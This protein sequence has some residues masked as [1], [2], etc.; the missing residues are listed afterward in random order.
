MQLRSNT[1]QFWG[2]SDSFVAS[3]LKLKKNGP[4]WKS[5]MSRRNRRYLQG[6][7]TRLIA[8]SA[9]LTELQKLLAEFFDAKIM[10]FGGFE[11]LFTYQKGWCHDDW[12]EYEQLSAALYDSTVITWKQKARVDAIRPMSAI[13]WLVSNGLLPQNVDAWGGPGRGTRTIR[14]NAFQSYLRTMPHTEWPSG[15]SCICQVFVEWTKLYNNG[16]DVIDLPLT[17]YPGCSAVEPGATPQAQL[18]YN[19]TSLATLNAVCSQSRQWAGVHFE[20]SLRDAPSI[21]SGIAAQGFAKLQ[22]LK[23]GVF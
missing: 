12:I 8:I 11:R 18:S 4:G 17:W 14:T 22:R 5:S 15:T 23:S 9:G 1:V 19:F 21:C 3:K 7:A 10:S 2:V 6:N 16:S 20:A 13:R